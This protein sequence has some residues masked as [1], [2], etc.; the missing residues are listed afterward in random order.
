MEVLLSYLYDPSWTNHIYTDKRIS[1]YKYNII[2]NY[3]YSK[4]EQLK[5]IIPKSYCVTLL[6]HK[7]VI[8]VLKAAMKGA[9]YKH[10]IEL[11]IVNTKL[12]IIE[13]IV[14]N[15]IIYEKIEF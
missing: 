10:I 1:K 6:P 12:K 4:L 7:S 3:L 8:T 15:S 2:R 11:Y 13:C 14:D 9:Y 5:K